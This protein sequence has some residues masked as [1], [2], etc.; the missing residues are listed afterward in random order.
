MQ[1][2]GTKHSLSG[3]HL[4]LGQRLARSPRNFNAD[5]AVGLPC[6]LAWPRLQPVAPNPPLRVVANAM[7]SVSDWSQ[8]ATAVEGFRSR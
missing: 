6:N 3:R 2:D 5:P 4:R 8:P 7:L 1:I